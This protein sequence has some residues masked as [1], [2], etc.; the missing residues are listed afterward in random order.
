MT[1]SMILILPLIFYFFWKNRN[2]KKK[3]LITKSIAKSLLLDTFS[4]DLYLCGYEKFVKTNSW[5]QNINIRKSIIERRELQLSAILKI[6]PMLR[7]EDQLSL[8]QAWRGYDVPTLIEE[9]QIKNYREDDFFI[10]EPPLA[11]RD[12]NIYL[13]GPKEF[14]DHILKIIS[15]LG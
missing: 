4:Y 10:C 9:G 2:E 6:L 11:Y 14:C 15:S 3:Y 5:A 13:N 8:Y 12:R 7:S 1:D